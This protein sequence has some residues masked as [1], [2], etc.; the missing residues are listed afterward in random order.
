MNNKTHRFMAVVE[1]IFAYVD[2]DTKEKGFGTKTV[3]CMALSSHKHITMSTLKNIQQNAFIIV[4]E[5]ISAENFD[6]FEFIEG[7]IHNIIYLGD[8]NDKEFNDVPKTDVH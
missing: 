4:S 8:M 3:N 5:S 2:K 7:T 6:N 1:V